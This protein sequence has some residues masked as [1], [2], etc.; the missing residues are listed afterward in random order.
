MV[1]FGGVWDGAFGPTFLRP[2]PGQAPSLHDT[3]PYAARHHT[4]ERS[5]G[6]SLLTGHRPNQHL[7]VLGAMSGHHY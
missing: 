7:A 1:F 4:V 6:W 3:L 2:G 5:N